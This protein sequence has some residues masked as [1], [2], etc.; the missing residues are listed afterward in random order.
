MVVSDSK[1]FNN[2]C[3]GA[4][5][6]SLA[7]GQSFSLFTVGTGTDASLPCCTLE[8]SRV[9]KLFNKHLTHG[10]EISSDHHK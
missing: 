2:K 4:S 5:F 8:C 1:N 3:I 7:R 10:H 9:S 6:S